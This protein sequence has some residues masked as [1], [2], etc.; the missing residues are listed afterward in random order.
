M[1]RRRHK[2]DGTWK[3]SQYFCRRDTNVFG[4]H[5]ETVLLRSGQHGATSE[6]PRF[7][8]NAAR[9]LVE[10]RYRVVR[11][12]LTFSTRDFQMVREVRGHVLPLQGLKMAPAGHHGLRRD[13]SSYQ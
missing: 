13:H 7:A 10:R 4:G 2:T 8:E 6:D 5:D 12:Q 11:K 3:R 1:A 9:T